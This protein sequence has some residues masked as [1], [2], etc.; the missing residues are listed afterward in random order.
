MA[1]WHPKF[2]GAYWCCFVF[3]ADSKA[4][5]STFR[6]L[7]LLLFSNFGS[8]HCRKCKLKSNLAAGENGTSKVTTS[9]ATN[10]AR[11][12]NQVRHVCNPLA[13]RHWLGQVQFETCYASARCIPF[14]G[15]PV[16]ATVG[17]V[18]PLSG[19]SAR[20]RLINSYPSLVGIPISGTSTSRFHWFIISSAALTVAATLH[21]YFAFAASELFFNSPSIRFVL[22]VAA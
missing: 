2:L 18:P 21:S 5:L 4:V 9:L 20:T 1:S 22:H 3:F 12:Q 13:W 11:F 8:F 17:M 15:L 14:A 16:S 19:P 7:H 6:I 10:L